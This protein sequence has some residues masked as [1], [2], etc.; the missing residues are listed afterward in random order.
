MDYRVQLR[1]AEKHLA[2][3]DP[4]LR[5]LIKQFGSC[6]LMP[7]TDY[8][9]AL[10]RSIVGQQLSV[11]AAR[12]IYN[13]LLGLYGDSTP[14]PEQL[15]ST[16]TEQLRSVGLSQRKAEYVQD[17]SRHVLDGRLDLAHVATLPND[18]LIAELVDVKGIGTWSAHMFLIFCL[19]RLD[20]L[21]VGD[22]GIVAA[23]TKVYD[24][25]ARPTPQA[26]AE[27]AAA[28]N[29]APYQSVASWY[30]WRSLDNTSNNT[31]L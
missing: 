5:V 23:M 19:G 12:T 31:V 15:L 7:H 4:R 28:N 14:T 16:S 22:L 10:L 18:E 24:L 29:W 27:L 21:P 11:K 13:R 2:K 25:P 26:V 1:V 9:R 3:V 20:I 30:L 8:F 6:D 17:L